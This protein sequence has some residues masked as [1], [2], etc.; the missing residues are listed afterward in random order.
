[1]LTDTASSLAG[2]APARALA[3]A[4][5]STNA[6]SAPISPASSASAMNSSGGTKP[7]RGW[8]QRTSASTEPISPVDEVDLRLVVELELA[9]LDRDPQLLDQL[10]PV[11][12][13]VE[14]L[15]V[16]R[17]ALAVE[18]GAVHREVGAAHEVGR[19][20]GVVGQR[21]RCRC[22]RRSGRAPRRA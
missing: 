21:P 17:E 18:L 7:R 10:H 14:V 5:S 4:S 8:I 3:S 11:G 12:G 13:A 22:W 1:M 16:D 19:V 2:G 20:G 15:L 9:L 6:V